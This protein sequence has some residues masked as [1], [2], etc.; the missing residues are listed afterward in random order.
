MASPGNPGT[1][2][3][4]FLAQATESPF[5]LRAPPLQIQVLQI[6]FSPLYELSNDATRAGLK[7]S[8]QD[9]YP[10]HEDFT[11]GGLK[12]MGIRFFDKHDRWS[13]CLTKSSLTL[14]TQASLPHEDALESFGHAQATIDQVFNHGMERSIVD[15]IGTRHVFRFPCHAPEHPLQENLQ[16]VLGSASGSGVNHSLID[17]NISTKEPSCQLALRTGL[18]AAGSSLGNDAL[19]PID[20]PSW[21]LDID[22]YRPGSV[23]IHNATLDLF[24]AT[25]LSQ[26]SNAIRWAACPQ[27]IEKYKIPDEDT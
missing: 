24:L 5:R 23:S 16:R 10:I 6:R 12:S 20:V 21:I 4:A 9:R 2:L 27:I 11:G 15:Y 26:T 13:L 3:R 22:A 7:A 19:A 14:S 17:I 1:D 18:L 25:F 8:L